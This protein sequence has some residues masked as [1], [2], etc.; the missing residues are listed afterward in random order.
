MS[1][2]RVQNVMINALNIMKKASNVTI[3]T[4]NIRP[5]KIDLMFLVSHFQK[6]GER[7]FHLSLFFQYWTS[8][9]LLKARKL[10]L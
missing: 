9:V 4:P 8:M 10:L 2:T 1:M 6:I 3:N 7:I 5:M